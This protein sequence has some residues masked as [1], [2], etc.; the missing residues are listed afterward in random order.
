M[1][2]KSNNETP[3]KD[4]QHEHTKNSTINCS[5]NETT[6]ITNNIIL[7]VSVKKDDLLYLLGD[8]HLTHQL[9]HYSQ[10][11]VYALLKL[12]DVYGCMLYHVKS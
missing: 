12:D 10:D 4:T 1:N 9:K 3:P 2:R 6:N 11:G 8:T 7:T 5:N